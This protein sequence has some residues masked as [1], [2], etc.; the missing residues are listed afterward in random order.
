M[1]V[2]TSIVH[3]EYLRVADA[4]SHAIYCGSDQEWYATEGQRLKGCG[5]SA[6]ANMLYYL[7]RK[8]SPD[9]CEHSKASLLTH[10]EEAWNY[11]T[12]RTSGISS[13]ALFCKKLESY[14]KAHGQNF[15]Y[16]TLDIPEQYLARPAL[17]EVVSFLEQGLC[18]DTPVAFLNLDNGDEHNLER[19]H[20]VTI[21]SVEQDLSANKVQVTIC[22]EGRCK[23]IDLALW[24]ET[25][26]LGGGFLY[27][28]KKQPNLFKR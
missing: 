8:Q 27:F 16:A 11:I 20:W 23:N 28:T 14:A 3:E 4:D 18:A 1:S 13:T 21:I 9:C 10:M 12:P 5:P 17:A 2:K 22:D 7:K 24:L 6:A 15:L 19:W 26:K 25:S